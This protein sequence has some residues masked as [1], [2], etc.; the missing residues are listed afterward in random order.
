[1]ANFLYFFPPNQIFCHFSFHLPHAKTNF[2]PSHDINQIKMFKPVTSNKNLVDFVELLEIINWIQNL[3]NISGRWPIYQPLARQWA[4]FLTTSRKTRVRL[5]QNRNQTIP[6]QFLS[7]TDQW[8]SS[9]RRRI[10][11]SILSGLWQVP[12]Q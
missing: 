6:L 5:Q 10:E 1:M 8:S 3:L 11:Q 9:P 7:S 2:N 4:D 12:R